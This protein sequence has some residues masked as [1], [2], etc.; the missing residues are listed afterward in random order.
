MYELGLW[1]F[2]LRDN[3][4]ADRQNASNYFTKIESEE[5]RKHLS[6][7]Q[8]KMLDLLL[9]ISRYSDTM[10]SD[11][12]KIGSGREKAGRIFSVILKKWFP[13]T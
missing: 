5:Y 6:D 13:E 7:E 4:P 2:F 10:D 3:T 11:L 1:Y 9:G 8:Q 12:A